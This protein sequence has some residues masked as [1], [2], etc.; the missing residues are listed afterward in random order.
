MKKLRSIL[1]LPFWI[2]FAPFSYA[3]FGIQSKLL[4]SFLLLLFFLLVMTVIDTLC[5]DVI[6]L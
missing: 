6:E 2:I 5:Q 3:Y 1:H 4:R